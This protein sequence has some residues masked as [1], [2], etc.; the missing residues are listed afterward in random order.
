MMSHRWVYDTDALA[1][2]QKEADIIEKFDHPNIVRML[3]RFAAFHTHFIVMEFCEGQTLADMLYIEGPLS[4]NQFRHI[5]SQL[6]AAIDYA[7]R[8]EVAHRD[9][10]PANIMVTPDGTVKLMDFGLAEPSFG[11]PRADGRIAGTPRYMA[12]EQRTGQAVGPEAD[13]FAFG[14]VVYEMLTGRPLF[15][16]DSTHEVVRPFTD[17]I[18]PSLSEI[19]PDLPESGLACLVSGF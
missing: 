19:R 18:P 8:A 4:D 17:W 9:I 13:F 6:A 1:S 14:C 2:F 16:L 3:G 5:A 10:K 11:G 15:D 12:P 7:H